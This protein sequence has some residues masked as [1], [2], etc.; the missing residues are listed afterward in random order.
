M[1]ATKGSGLKKFLGYILLFLIFV[2]LIIGISYYFGKDRLESLFNNTNSSLITVQR[3]TTTQVTNV[4]KSGQ[5]NAWSF[6]TWFGIAVL[7]A[8]L[9]LLAYKF[10]KDKTILSDKSKANCEIKAYNELKE[11]GYSIGFKKAKWSKP[12]YGGDEQ[13]NPFWA[14]IFFSRA[15]TPQEDI[16]TVSKFELISCFVDAK[17]LKVWNESKGR[18]IAII[19]KEMHEQRFGKES[20]PDYPVKTEREP[21]DF[22]DLFTDKKTSL[23]V[24]LGGDEE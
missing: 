9:A 3:D 7:I 2:L 4:D 8:F 19:T 20:I 12:G 5:A 22:Q 14:F 24:P 16:N 1:A 21:K 17:T 6:A 10:F 13:K 11:R 18:D 15:V 23:N